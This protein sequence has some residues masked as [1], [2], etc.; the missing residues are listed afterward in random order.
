MDREPEPD[1]SVLN[2]KPKRNCANC[3]KSLSKSKIKIFAIKSGVGE[4]IR[5]LIEDTKGELISENEKVCGSCFNQFLRMIKDNDEYRSAHSSR[6]QSP[7]QSQYSTPCSSQ[8]SV[9]TTSSQETVPEP[10]QIS[11]SFNLPKVSGTDKSCFVCENKRYAPLVKESVRKQILKTKK[12]FVPENYRCCEIHYVNNE[13]TEADL[14]RINKDFNIT[15][16]GDMCDWFFDL[17]CQNPVESKDLPFNRNEDYKI[18]T[19]LSKSQFDEIHYKFIVNLRDRE[20]STK[21][22][23]GIYLTKLRSGQSNSQLSRF[24]NINEGTIP[25]I[26][27]NVRTELIRQMVGNTFNPENWTRDLI[28]SHQSFMVTTLHCEPGS[29]A[30]MWDGT[31]YYIQKSNDNEFQRKTYSVQKGRHLIKPMI[32]IAAD[33]YILG[34]FGPFEA[35]QNDASIMNKIIEKHEKD[36]DR[37]LKGNDVFIV[38]RGFRD[39]EMLQK[40]YKVAMPACVPP[41]QPQMTT[42]QANKTRFVTKV[43]YKI[44]VVNGILKQN[45]LLANTRFNSMIDSAIDDWKIA[46]A[47]Y[48]EFFTPIESD[49]GFEGFVAQK[50]ISRLNTECELKDKAT[51][52]DRKSSVWKLID[53]SALPDFPVLDENNI[54][55]FTLGTYQIKMCK[56]YIL[57]HISKNS[58]FQIQYCTFP[59]ERNLIRVKLPSRHVANKVYNVY[60]KYEPNGQGYESITNYYCKCKSGCRTVGCCTHV[61]AVVWYLSHARHNYTNLN[62]HRNPSSIFENNDFEMSENEEM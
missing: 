47:I 19:G 29:I 10:E 30:T 9:V 33:G 45:N 41:K 18:F 58:E 14:N 28:Q 5:K 7:V 13:L 2:R 36:F 11:I 51:Q 60:I 6:I 4:Q 21:K 37:I 35:K 43:R 25:R 50:M 59:D 23:L 56:S 48:N 40:K 12:F 55:C 15:L 3:D 39:A 53:Q 22:K 27:R 61:C 32:A 42:E 31:Y 34:V 52:L 26:V 62:N 44:E 54:L 57:E 49:K 17:M 20:I 16:E 38:D 8:Q 1:P 24:F 46:A